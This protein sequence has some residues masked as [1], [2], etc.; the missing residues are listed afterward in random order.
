MSLFFYKVADL[1]CNFIKIETL[2][3]MFCCEFCEISLNT[4]SCRTLLVAASDSNVFC[5]INKLNASFCIISQYM[6]SIFLTWILWSASKPKNVLTSLYFQCYF[7]RSITLL[8]IFLAFHAYF[9]LESYCYDLILH[10][11][12]KHHTL[13]V[14]FEKHWPNLLKFFAQIFNSYFSF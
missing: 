13:V 12:F 10:E 6:K 5:K 3:Q 14:Q 9:W 4:F 8:L 2:A 11:A 1:A 7:L